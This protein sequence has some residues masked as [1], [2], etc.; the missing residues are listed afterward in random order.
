MS[1]LLADAD[2]SLALVR[3][4]LERAP[5]AAAIVSGA[6][7]GRI[8]T[9]AEFRS[10]SAGAEAYAGIG[11]PIADALPADARGDVNALLDRVRRNGIAAHDARVGLLWLCD[12]WPA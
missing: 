5:M 11:D 12:V 10:V 6:A 3:R 4:F 7:H 2:A 9:N 8:F 1:L